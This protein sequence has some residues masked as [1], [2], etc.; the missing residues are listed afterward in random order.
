MLFAKSYHIMESNM[1]H[2]TNYVT[3]YVKETG[4]KKIEE[5]E[6]NEIEFLRLRAGLKK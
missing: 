5:F 6:D 1:T 4:V 2:V 3:R